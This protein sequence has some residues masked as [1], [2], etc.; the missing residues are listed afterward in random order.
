MRSLLK[1]LFY[2]VLLAVIVVGG[3]A[4]A[5]MV[6]P[7]DSLARMIAGE[8]EKSTGR[9]MT[10]DGAIERS[11]FPVL[12]V[13][14]G[15]VAFANAEWARSGP[16]LTA[17]SAE[18][19]L[20]TLP[21]L[22][23]SIEVAKIAVAKPVIRLEID[24]RGRRSWD[25]AKV[26]VDTGAGAEIG[27]AVE[28][29]SSG[30]GDDG[31]TLAVLV[32]SIEV[33][34]GL[35]TILDHGAGGAPIEVS[36]I[37]LNGS[38][39]SLEDDF[40]MNGTAVAQGRPANLNVKLA[41]PAALNRGET[42]RL[43][44]FFEADGVSARIDGDVRAP[45]DG[46]AP[47]AKGQLKLALD[48]DKKRTAW[49]RAL[50]PAELEPLEAV[51]IDGVFDA[52]AHGLDVALDGRFGFRGEPTVLK[53]TAKAGPGWSDGAQPVSTDFA[54]SNRLL[55]AGFHGT[56]QQ[57]PG[58][59]LPQ[60][61]G[62][63]R[64]KAPDAQALIAWSGA[65]KPAPDSPNALLQ[66][67]DLKGGVDMKPEHLAAAM[68]GA[69][70]FNGKT[71]AIEAGARGGSGW[72]ADGAFETNLNASAPRL[73]T[74]AWK[75]EVRQAG[76]V[77]NGDMRFAS[78][79]L[80]DFFEWLGLGAIDAPK[81]SF[82][83]VSF[84]SDVAVDPG[85]GA[86]EN[87]A[88][89]LDKNA[90]TGRLTYDLTG[91]RPAVTAAL[92]SDPID[93]RPF[94]RAASRGGGARAGGGSSGRGAAPSQTGWSKDPLDLGALHLVDA[95]LDVQTAGLATSMLV[96]GPSHVTARLKAGRLEAAIKQMALY[97]GKATGAAVIDG[98]KATP[99][100]SVTLDVGGVQLRPLLNDAA[101]M[102]WLEGTGALKA[103]I[104]G[105]GGSQDA[106]M[107]SLNGS[108]SIDFR[109]GAIIG[110]NLAAMVRNIT[111]LGQ[112]AETQKT[113]FSEMRA[114]FRIDKG[115][116][117][118]SDLFMAGP[119]VRLT[120]Q[121]A[122]DIGNQTIDYTLR[123]KAVA[124]LTGQGGGGQ[125]LTGI[126][127]PVRVHGPWANTSVEPQLDAEDL[128]NNVEVLL[129]SPE[130]AGAFLKQLE[131]GGLGDVLKGV[132]GDAKTRDAVEGLLKGLAGEQKDG[133][134]GGGSLLD[135][136]FGKKK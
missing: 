94:T 41:S 118:N 97:G 33:A 75:G 113:D 81:G 36:A 109:N 100:M 67:V 120:G 62:E 125:Q 8:V 123:P 65:P 4:V 112:S 132:T 21:L 31:E 103:D 5:F 10:I 50:L 134:G 76:Q 38:F 22:F 106:L 61:A 131:Q 135:G 136:L 7:S 73:F 85:K 6:W 105:A 18:V 2:L 110:Y 12:G 26:D 28:A 83:S 111:S 86:L 104:S 11:V 133:E 35:L 88:L 95:D 128:I 59:A 119:L 45:R 53:G 66:S 58:A 14:L 89:T 99:A 74:A 34:D 80:R 84:K 114:S 91:E 124:T 47:E 56:A 52:A 16:L 25:L 69:V 17:D 20:R 19:G 46:G 40:L 23:G 48:G 101:A 54:V 93:I 3:G 115:V 63:Y 121:G 13:K 70:G 49:V 92:K 37:T 29:P 108:T 90:V 55:D 79:A 64:L 96:I 98:S 30:G 71:V 60:L 15:R 102:D 122:I 77:V 78:N 129:A 57:T 51:S 32:E 116:A 87:L 82:E 24:K 127:V 42:A 68:T 117:R 43:E 44:A 72:D 1:I 107:R 39:A 27:R 126:V 130:G 9:R